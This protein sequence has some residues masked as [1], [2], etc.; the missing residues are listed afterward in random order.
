MCD[1]ITLLCR[2]LL[3]NTPACDKARAHGRRTPHRVRG[4]RARSR[5][6]ALAGSPVHHCSPRLRVRLRREQ[7]AGVGVETAGENVGV[8]VAY[9][10]AHVQA[11]SAEVGAAAHLCAWPWH[12]A[13]YREAAA[14]QQQG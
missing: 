10:A 14:L 1:G 11:P 9:I 2:H 13:L 12:V 6:H 3:C 5:L 4:M 8:A 7:V